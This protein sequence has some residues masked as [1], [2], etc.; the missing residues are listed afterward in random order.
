[1]DWFFSNSTR[2]LFRKDRGSV[3]QGAEGGGGI[4]ARYTKL[5]R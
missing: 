2:D 5:E 3:M 4:N 1:M